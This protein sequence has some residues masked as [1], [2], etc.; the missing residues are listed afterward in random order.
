VTVKIRLT[1]F[2]THTRARTLARATSDGAL[3]G[4]VGVGLLRE[5]APDRPL[6][7]LGLRVVGLDE[8][9]GPAQRTL[10]DWPADVLGEAEM[11][12]PR[13]RRLDD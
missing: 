9:A 10:R 11:W 8:E 7:L 12:R 4:E 6:R 1:G 3:L 13:Q 2:E 5:F